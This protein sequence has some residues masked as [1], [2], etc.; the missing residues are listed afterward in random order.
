MSI[1]IDSWHEVDEDLKDA[2]WDDIKVFYDYFT[3][4]YDYLFIF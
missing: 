3:T 4:I 1:L 2:I